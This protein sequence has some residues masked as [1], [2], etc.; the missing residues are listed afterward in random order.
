MLFAAFNIDEF[1]ENSL[2]ANCIA[3]AIIERCAHL[4]GLYLFL[5]NLD[6][7]L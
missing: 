7:R 1:N 2:G 6:L 3:R 4:N 5:I